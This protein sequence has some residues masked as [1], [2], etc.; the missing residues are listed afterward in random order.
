VRLVEFEFAKRIV[1]VVIE[2]L[3]LIVPRS[4]V[5][6]QLLIR[7]YPI[8]LLILMVRWMVVLD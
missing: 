7:V 2:L 5:L 3:K 1:I 8:P 6:K 4:A